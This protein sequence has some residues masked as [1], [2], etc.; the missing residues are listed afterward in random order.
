MSNSTDDEVALDPR[1]AAQ[2][3]TLLQ[4]LLLNAGLS[5]GLLVTGL[6]ADSSGLIANALDNA[7]DAAVYAISYVAVTRPP[8]WKALAASASGVLL[9]VLSIGVMA[10]VARR[11][12]GG[13]EPMG[14]AMIA[15]A[16]VAAAVNALCLKL[17]ARHRGA[18][19]NLRA[20]WT[21]SINDFLSNFGILVAAALVIALGRNWPDL[22]IGLA[23]AAVAAYGGITILRDAARSRGGA[24]DS[25]SGHSHD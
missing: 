18:D 13:G 5:G 14:P 6:A 7:S 15:M 11:F 23:I 8:R 2:R 12:A 9:L 1:D 4:V 25:H 24:A 10:D 3:R 22:V 20:A 21:F 17:L 19:V 16:F